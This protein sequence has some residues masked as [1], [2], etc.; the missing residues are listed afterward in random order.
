MERASEER[1]QAT[2]AQLQSYD[3]GLGLLWH[4]AF[5]RYAVIATWPIGDRRYELIQKG[6]MANE[7][8]DILGW[9]ASDLQ[10]ADSAGLDLESGLEKQ[11]FAILKKADNQQVPWKLRLA[12]IAEKNKKLRDSRKAEI[13]QKAVDIARDLEYMVGHNEDATMRRIMNDITKEGMRD[14]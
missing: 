6:E 2:K 14:E 4:Q 12:Q 7:P 9:L 13:V 5:R 10:D 8:Y 1:E 3:T 11:I